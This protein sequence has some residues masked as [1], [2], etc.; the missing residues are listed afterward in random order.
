MMNTSIIFMSH[1]H[2]WLLARR[3]HSQVLVCHDSCLHM[4][5]QRAAASR[6]PQYSTFYRSR[7]LAQHGT[8]PP[9]Q[10]HTAAAFTC[11]RSTIHLAVAIL[12]HTQPHAHPRTLLLPRMEA[13]YG[14]AVLWQVAPNEAQLLTPPT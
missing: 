5:R 8:E 1:R 7:G 3:K 12:R 4:Q 13:H 6:T 2:N 9:R 14:H 10:G 11:S